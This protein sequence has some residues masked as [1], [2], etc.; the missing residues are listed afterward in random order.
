MKRY[1]S[2]SNLFLGILLTAVFVSAILLFSPLW[3]QFEFDGDEG[4]N[5]GQ[6]MLLKQGHAI[7]ADFWSDQPPVFNYLLAAVIKYF[8]YSVPA[9]RLLVLAFSALLFWCTFQILDTFTDLRTALIGLFLLII[10]GRF[11]E[12]S[13]WVLRGLP[14]ISLA[15]F[16]LY[17]I[18]MWERSS[19]H[20]WLALSAGTLALSVATKLFTG[21]LAPVFFIGL[22]IFDL[23]SC[24]N[25]QNKLAAYK[26]TIFWAAIFATVLGLIVFL[27]I[28]VENLNDLVKPH[29]EARVLEE[30]QQSTLSISFPFLI[31]A[32]L[33]SVIIIREKKW[34][35]LFPI[36][37]TI[38]AYILLVNHRPVGFHQELLITT[39]AILLAAY[40]VNEGFITL[41][42]L[43][44]ARGISNLSEIR[45]YGW[46]ALLVFLVY[47]TTSLPPSFI[48]EMSAPS[49]PRDSSESFGSGAIR[50]LAA[51]DGYGTS[52]GHIL[53]DRPMFAYRAGVKMLPSR[54][55]I[56]TGKRYLTGNIREEEIIR[57]IIDLEPE[58]IIL[59][60]FEYPAVSSF[61][62]ESEQYI[63]LPYG[64]RNHFL[65]VESWD[66]SSWPPPGLNLP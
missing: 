60:R 47:L 43:F 12:L 35:L 19:K 18:L 56:I 41:R 26:P 8:G 65:I 25:E 64:G 1:I 57:A 21:L 4:V 45:I 42:N 66:E 33:G 3:S 36:S 58:H 29:L 20:I 48:N 13:Y 37:W 54:V 52:S 50:T 9:S 39:P 27:I 2:N 5:L 15:V 53:T 34:N 23:K 63:V 61:L 49:F 44:R 16:S 7:Y 31:L 55:S 17:A 46:A 24:K 6:A 40:A 10:T 11:V 59:R 51:L 32:L 30:Y 38:F 14:A 62:N 22:F 28:G